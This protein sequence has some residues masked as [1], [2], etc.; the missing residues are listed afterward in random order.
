MQRKILRQHVQAATPAALV[1][2]QRAVNIHPL[3][4]RSL[5]DHNNKALE[6][7][8][9][10]LEKLNGTGRHVLAL[11]GEG[12]RF[13]E[14]KFVYDELAS[15]EALLKFTDQWYQSLNLGYQELWELW[16]TAPVGYHT[17]NRK[18]I[19]TTVN[20][21]EAR[22]LGYEVDEM[23]GKRFTSFVHPKQ[24]SL[25]LSR[26]KQKLAGENV[27]PIQNRIYIRKD[28][29]HLN[30]SANDYI[31]HNAKGR[32]RGVKTV[33]VDI[34]KLRELEKQVWLLIK[35]Q[36]LSQLAAGFA[37]E[38][39]NLMGAILPAAQTARKLLGESSDPSLALYLDNIIEA[40]VIARKLTE[41]IRSYA[42]TSSSEIMTDRLDPHQITERVI[43]MMKTP[44]KTSAPTIRYRL[45]TTNRL[46]IEGIE[47]QVV[48]TLINL[49]LNA[50]DVLADGGYISLN[51]KDAEFYSNYKTTSGQILGPG[52]YVAISVKDNGPGIK[53]DLAAQVFEP[54]FTTKDQ[55][56]NSGFGLSILTRI[57]DLHGGGVDL[58]TRPG[59]GSKFTIYFPAIEAE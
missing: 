1:A 34:T 16:N 19:I 14:G 58:K 57:M 45:T 9:F 25:A 27:P 10:H 21:T 18:G 35:Q 29:S 4:A 22:M 33:L 56:N 43:S 11:E 51:I 49:C 6:V 20:E 47:H 42:M 15:P 44:K 7:M 39:G 28:G 52:K 13:R 17:L 23:H 53:R 32:V 5:A 12:L 36:E 59:Q 31:V 46:F 8:G 50:Q 41:G 40:A 37:H 26:F 24:K 48:Q 38:F 54:F 55:S 30:V 3:L 2:L